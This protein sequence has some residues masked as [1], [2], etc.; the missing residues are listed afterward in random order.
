MED[1]GPSTYGD[2]IA[3][4]YDDLYQD[5]FD[6]D[7]TVTFLAGYARGG[8]ALEL[9]VGTGRIAL[10]LAERGVE[11][12]GVDASEAMVA[13]MRAK[14][15]G[16]R[17][18][19]AMGNFVDPPVEGPFDLIY[20]PFNTLFGLTSQD[21]QIR[22]FANIAAL[23]ADEGVFALDAFVPDLTRFDRHQRFSVERIEDGI[24][25][26]DATRHDPM[27]QRSSTYHLALSQD[28]IEMFPVEIRYAWPSELDLMGRLA[29][30]RLAERWASYSREP[31]GADS[32]SHVSVYER[33]RS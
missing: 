13:K 19:V 28:G 8:R 6:I 10:P 17:I 31:F 21:E 9:G 3:G 29:G 20:I 32:P 14:P 7:A 2:A 1:Y 33:A 11:V 27:R 4:R 22:C 12:H 15:G 24:V 30:L 25:Y 18:T 26:V 5:M 23:L 16:D